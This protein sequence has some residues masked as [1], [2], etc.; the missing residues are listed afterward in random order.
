[1]TRPY[2]ILAIG[3]FAVSQAAIIIRL[4]QDQD[5]PSLV[6]AAGRLV[7]ASIILTPMVLRRSHYRQQMRQLKPSEMRLVFVSGIFLAAHFSFW[8]SSL[9]YT[10]VLISAVLV[11]TTPIWVAFLELFFLR[12]KL[13][14]MVLMGLVIALLGGV[15]IGLSDGGS[16]VSSNPILGAALSVTGAIAV[17]VYMI[18]G[19]KLRPTLALAPY[20]WMVYGI[21]ATTMLLV[22]LVTGTPVTGYEL[23]GYGWVLALA[24]LPQLIGHTSLNYALGY[25]PATY[26]SVATQSEPILSA[27][28]AY[29]I[30]T[31][32]PGLF[33]VF[34]GVVIMVGVLVATL[35]QEKPS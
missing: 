26:I 33:Q 30:F 5:V 31:E 15:F 2:I 18:I 28:V 32:V 12:A 22:L 4:A 9:E 6:I 17:A 13:S 19:R 14:R 7:I 29:F 24:L 35:G 10:T 27:I 20:I 21:A 11:T 25:L 34:G 8:V 1:M 16:E 3:V 23:A